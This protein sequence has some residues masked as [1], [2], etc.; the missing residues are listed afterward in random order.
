MTQSLTSGEVRNENLFGPCA[1]LLELRS[2]RDDGLGGRRRRARGLR[3][4]RGETCA[5][6]CAGRYRQEVGIQARPNGSVATVD[7]LSDYDAII[8]GT[9][10]RY[11]NM[12]AH[13]KNFFDQTGGLWFEDK[14]VGK[15][16]SRLYL[17]RY[18]GRDG[19][20]ATAERE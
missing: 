2:R 6:A 15:V 19:W 10:T 11:G 5:G 9:P 4:C 14:P 3:G 7:E 1:F 17:N 8:F 13:M 18:P 12:T 20:Q 16:G